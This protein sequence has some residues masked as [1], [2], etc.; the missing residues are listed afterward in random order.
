MVR[1]LWV[2]GED[3]HLALY[4]RGW[5]LVQTAAGPALQIWVGGGE[6]FEGVAPPHAETLAWN[7]KTKSF[8]TVAA[9]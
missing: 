6:S 2:A 1:T 5:Q 4:V 7:P 3:V 8:D 9:P